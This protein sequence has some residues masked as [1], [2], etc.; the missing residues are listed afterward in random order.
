MIV[1]FVPTRLHRISD[2]V[3]I[4]ASDDTIV[5]TLTNHVASYQIETVVWQHSHLELTRLNKLSGLFRIAF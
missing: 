5:H 1:P 4:A 2:S 3:C